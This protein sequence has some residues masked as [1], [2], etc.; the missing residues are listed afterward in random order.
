MDGDPVLELPFERL[1]DALNKKIS[2]G[3]AKVPSGVPLAFGTL[4]GALAVEVFA[5][6]W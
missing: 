3:C 1:I 5:I 4:V 6:G 2:A